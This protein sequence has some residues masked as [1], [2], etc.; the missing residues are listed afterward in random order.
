MSR[1]SRRAFHQ[2]FTLVELLV[3]IAIIG[4]LVSLLLPAV[5]AAREA[6][7]RS[8][9]MNNLRQIGL[10]LHTYHDTFRL[11]PPSYLTVPGGG[12][13]MG[14]P[15]PENGDAGPGW[16]ALMLLLPQI[17]QANLY[18]SFDLG[19]PSWSAKNAAPSKQTVQTYLC[20][21]ANH[22]PKTYQV[23]DDGGKALATFAR[24]NYVAHAGREDLWDLPQADLS[25]IADGSFYR[26]SRTRMAEIGDGLS[27]TI[28][29][30]EQTPTRSDST[31]VGIVPGAV[32]C[33]TLRYAFAG[34]DGAAPQINV[35]SGPG[36]GEFPPLI[37]TP[38]DP[39]GY[40]DEMFCDHPNGCN[41]LLGDGSVRFAARSI[42]G[43]TWAALATRA[44]GDTIG[45]W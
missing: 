9:C 18:N 14:P 23:V 2:G 16:T 37:H 3:V 30:G 24:S 29:F 28:F 8:Q 17:E 44:E 15:D 4:V 21:S 13:A 1:F 26:N 45:D 33:P 10:A 32:T 20:P 41:V 11:F 40:V 31:W 6:A 27:N 12:G 5:Q 7:R 42:N 38:N 22:H 25:R 43:A 39:F 34:C 35:H 36:A 19:S